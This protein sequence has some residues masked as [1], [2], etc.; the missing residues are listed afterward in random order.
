MHWFSFDN[1]QSAEYMVN[2]L[3]AMIAGR[4]ATAQAM[5]TNVAALKHHLP[6][7]N[8]LQVWDN[9]NR[10]VVSVAMGVCYRWMIVR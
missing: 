3:V 10:S 4:E 8:T 6:Q 2:E 1:I 5:D 7:L 9:L